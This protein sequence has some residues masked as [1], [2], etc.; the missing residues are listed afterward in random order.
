MG[1]EVDLLKNYPK[2][3]RNLD[4]RS[5]KKSEKD[6]E[7]ARKFGKDFFDGER[8]Y[9]YGGFNYNEKFWTKVIPDFVNYWKMED[10]CSLLDI[11]CAKGFMLFDFKK[12]LSNIKVKGIDISDYAINNA[13]PDIKNELFVYDINNKL[14]FG[15]NSFDYVISINTVHNLEL[16]SC[17]KAIKE[18]ERVSNKGSFITVDAYRNDLEK[19]RMFDWNLTAKTIMS[20]AEWKKIFKEI[21]YKGDYYWFI[22]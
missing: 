19:K 17:I 3:K 6:R 18:I 8:R 4:E 9:G 14:P 16:E 20:V 5:Q 22:P 21:E 11:G 1:I 13:H 10:N 7:I 15:D 2:S 12:Y